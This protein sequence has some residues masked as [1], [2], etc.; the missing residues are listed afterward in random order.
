MSRVDSI[1]YF[2]EST[3]SPFASVLDM[4]SSYVIEYASLSIYVLMVIWVNLSLTLRDNFL[5][6][7]FA[8]TD[9]IDYIPCMSSVGEILT[10]NGF[11]T[12]P[13]PEITLL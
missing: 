10:L 11:L 2:A 5:A 13:N 4:A 1:R 12:D 7:V 8:W 9:D 3:N 6:L